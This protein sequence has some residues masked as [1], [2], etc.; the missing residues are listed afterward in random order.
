MVEASSMKEA[1]LST[2]SIIGVWR[3]SS[4]NKSCQLA[5]PQTKLGRAY[6]A[7]PIGCFGPI[8]TIR[9]WNVSGQFLN[10]YDKTGKIV[11]ALTPS[12]GTFVGKTESN[13]MVILSR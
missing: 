9:S 2:R 10:F 1:G 12:L 6:R 8:A 3:V 13:N 11:I 7:T 4:E 5:T